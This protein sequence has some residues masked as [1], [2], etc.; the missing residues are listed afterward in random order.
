M[1]KLQTEFN[2][3]AKQRYLNAADLCIFSQLPFVFFY[4][5]LCSTRFLAVSPCVLMLTNKLDNMQPHTGARKHRLMKEFQEKAEADH[6][7]QITVACR[8]VCRIRK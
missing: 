3:H 2:L 7:M 8:D 4:S 1:P 5:F 6:I